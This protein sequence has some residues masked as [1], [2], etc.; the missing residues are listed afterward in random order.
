MLD[1]VCLLDGIEMTSDLLYA[2][3]RRPNDVIIASEVPDKEILGSGG[4]GLVSTVG[5]RL[6]AAGLVKRELD[7]DTESLQE[8]QCSDSDFRKDHVDVAGNK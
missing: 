1:V 2:T 6:S 4:I 5:H 8:L 7:V 3:A